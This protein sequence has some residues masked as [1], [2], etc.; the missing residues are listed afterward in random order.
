MPLHGWARAAALKADSQS[1]SAA[2]L[3]HSWFF[4]FNIREVSGKVK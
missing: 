4:R 1:F 3:A 2:A